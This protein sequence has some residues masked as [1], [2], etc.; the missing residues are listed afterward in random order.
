M[1]S[2]LH[3][4]AAPLP[5][6]P[7][8]PRLRSW[9]TAVTPRTRCWRS[10]RR[11][12]RTSRVSWRSQ[13][14]ACTAS[15]NCPRPASSPYPQWTST[16]ALPR[17]DGL[18]HCSRRFPAI[19]Q[20]ISSINF[21]IT[22]HTAWKERLPRHILPFFFSWKTGRIFWRIWL[23]IAPDSLCH[24]FMGR[25]RLIGGCRVWF[26]LFMI[27]ATWTC[28]F[29]YGGRLL[30]GRRVAS[31]KWDFLC[32]ILYV[33]RRFPALCFLMSSMS[34]FLQTKFDNLYSCRE[35]ILDAWVDC[36]RW[37]DAWRGQLK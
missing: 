2:R 6:A 12:S 11:C 31:H 35:S 14:R 10:T 20:I 32:D 18:F 27:T 15:T 37:N 16:T 17:L 4:S 3:C 8:A 7:I 24:W 23:A 36:C 26:A 22:M 1:P 28:A 30:A 34:L 29:C 25:C 33:V 21:G 5:P 13:W 19:K 9:M